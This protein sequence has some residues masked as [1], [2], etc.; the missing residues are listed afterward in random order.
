MHDWR[1]AAAAVAHLLK[2]QFGV[3]PHAV[4]AKGLLGA[5]AALLGSEHCEAGNAGGIPTGERLT[6][7]VTALYRVDW[8]NC[9][10]CDGH[11]LAPKQCSQ[12]DAATENPHM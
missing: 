12:P 1:D 7:L 5:A 4:T 6:I 9:T 10:R 3:L 8:L 2:H 11:L